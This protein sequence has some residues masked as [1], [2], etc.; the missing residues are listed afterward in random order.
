MCCCML[1]RR[2][3]LESEVLL[4]AVEVSCL[5]ERGVAACRCFWRARC[6][7]VLLMPVALDSDVLLRGVEASCF[8]S[9]VLLRASCFWR[10]GCCCVLLFRCCVLLFAE[11]GV[12][13]WC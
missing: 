2:V 5:G 10:A 11:Q 9:E 8:E 6:C 7:C 13:A 3:A 1:L 12:A 4:R